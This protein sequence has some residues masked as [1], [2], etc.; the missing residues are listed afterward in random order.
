MKWKEKLL[1]AFR[2]T[3]NS[4]GR[5]MFSV[6]SV[7]LG[8]AAIAAVSAFSVSLEKAVGAQSRLLMG[9]DMRLE[10]GEPLHRDEPLAR[11]LRALGA[12]QAETVEFYTMLRAV[13]GKK[14]GATRLVRLRA[15]SGG[16]PF[17]GRI[18]S[19]P[20]AAMA[21]VQ[22][23]GASAVLDSTLFPALG[24]EPGSKVSVGK[25]RL[26]AAGRLVTEPG[27]PGF[28]T[29]Y[30]PPV[31]IP[32]S[33]LRDT[34]LIET[35]SRIRYSLFFKT[36]Q[37]FDA[38]AWKEKN[39]ESAAKRNITIYTY[40]EAASSVRRFMDNLGKF[41]TLA[42]LIILFLGGLGIGL[43]VHVFLKS[44]LQDIAVARALGAA[45]S[46]TLQIYLIPGIVLAAAGSLAGYA[47]GVG[48]AMAAV[49]LG[50]S[51]LPV[52]VV[53]TP[54]WQSFFASVVPGIVLTLA[55]TLFPVLRLRNLPVLS[56]LRRSEDYESQE[57]PFR[58]RLA[59]ALQ[60][61]RTELMLLSLLLLLV[62]GV[63]S[64]GSASIAVGASF[65]GG[66]VAASL[67]LFGAAVLLSSLAR[68]MIPWMRS[69]RL[70]QGIANLYR[71]G[72]Q[73]AVMLVAVGVGVLLIT[74]IYTA[75]MALQ[76]ELL[77]GRSIARPNLY[78]VDIQTS[79]KEEVES[80]VKRYSPETR[81]IPMVSMRLS[82]LNGEPVD[83]GD[84]ERNAN[85]R[86]WENSLRSYEYFAS[87]RA[88]LNPAE[89]L[90]RGRLWNE[91]PEQQELSVDERWAARMNVGLGDRIT[92]DIS[93]LPL[94]ARVTS[95]RRIDWA[96]MQINSILLFSPGDIENAPRMY[97]AAF[98][99]SDEKT[100][101]RF[102]E[103]LVAA[104]PSV[105]VIDAV[106]AA[107]TLS[108]IAENIS[109]VIQWM[110]GATLAAGVVILAGCIG[111]G[112]FARVRESALFKTLGAGRG[113]LIV[114]L[115][116]EY[117]LLGFLGAFGGVVLSQLVAWPVLYYLFELR[118]LV[119]WS[120]A[121]GVILFVTLL[122]VITG[123][124]VGGEVASRKPLEI[125]REET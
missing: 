116:A 119:P 80:F 2:Q 35:G 7:V 10:S 122:S 102:Q 75:Q 106:Q 47:L 78:L 107:Q 29:G 37:G 57:E 113:D 69:Y 43:S 120:F 54:G 85:R 40:G 30:G 20:E 71:P 105:T 22:N 15:V 101:F 55:F 70:R 16:Y 112:R 38:E 117:A 110:A 59:N 18:K 4:R 90:T 104:H 93:G 31:Y 92:F 68:R 95:M 87:Y 9:A 81:L 60:S 5:F 79:E 125:L 12:E 108:G 121:A 66:V 72:N 36:P 99:I 89:E 14:P 11:E 41:L 118:P 44:R 6:F 34:G 19:E 46:L 32:V 114:I 27:S 63:S 39:W 124:L 109:S 115:S 76:S 1:Y 25:T 53:V 56:V 91:R 62:L 45:P 64:L 100:R 77:P 65:T 73:T 96:A 33:A 86:N 48:L 61:N 28:S 49:G 3:R 52:E 13:T 84:I 51:F 42:G 97:V 21:R 83:R 94:E 58:T 103:E 8:V 24:L 98:N 74:T 26:E 23:G 123:F 111:A 50:K 67:V 17:Y 82:A 88:G